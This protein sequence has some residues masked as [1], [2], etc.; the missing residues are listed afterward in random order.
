[1]SMSGRR[2]QERQKKCDVGPTAGRQR[3][4][5]Q[6]LSGRQRHPADSGPT[7]GRRLQAEVDREPSESRNAVSTFTLN[8]NVWRDLLL[9]MLNP[10]LIDDQLVF[11]YQ[12]FVYKNNI[13]TIVKQLVIASD[14]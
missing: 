10:S 7:A 2:R 9:H 11:V 4:E 6:F 5:R 12:P 3:L 13:C 14:A 1:M 8:V